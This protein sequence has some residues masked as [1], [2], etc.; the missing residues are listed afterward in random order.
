MA[1]LPCISQGYT[2]FGLHF[3]SSTWPPVHVESDANDS[4]LF[5]L[6]LLPISFHLSFPKKKC[7]EQSLVAPELR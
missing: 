1:L 3:L 5:L 7:G 6:E 2:D 4:T